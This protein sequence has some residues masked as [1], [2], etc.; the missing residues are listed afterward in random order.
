MQFIFLS[1]ILQVVFSQHRNCIVLYWYC[2]ASI[3]EEQEPKVIK[4]PLTPIWYK[5]LKAGLWLCLKFKGNL[6]TMAAL[7]E[8]IATAI[9]VNVSHHENVRT[10]C[11]ICVCDT[12]FSF[13]SWR[14]QKQPIC[15]AA[16]PLWGERER[17]LT[18]PTEQSSFFTCFH[19]TSSSRVLRDYL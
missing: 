15:C 10:T 12:N 3:S 16:Q 9:H 6:E 11:I 4:C 17:D 19:S 13:R 8:L 5:I 18:F 1:S 7:M 2:F 14:T